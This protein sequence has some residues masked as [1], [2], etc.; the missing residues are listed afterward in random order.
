MV[1]SWPAGGWDTREVVSG[2]PLTCVT[3][4]DGPDAAMAGA[5]AATPPTVTAAAAAALSK[6]LF[7]GDPFLVTRALLPGEP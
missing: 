7:M 3:N 5:A 6:I 1:A 4:W 2:F